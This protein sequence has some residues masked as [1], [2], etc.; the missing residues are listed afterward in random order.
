MSDPGLIERLYTRALLAIGRGRITAVSDG[1]AV[2]TMQVRLGADE[3][4]DDTP[5]LVE[6]GLSSVPPIGSDVVLLFVGGDR[7]MGVVVASGNQG[8]RPKGLAGGEVCLYDDL[9]Q[10]VH[11]TRHGVVVKGAG[12]PIT[13]EGT[14]SLTIKA[15]AK[16]RLETPLLEVTGD[17]VDQVGGGGRSMA[18]MRAIYNEHTHNGVQPGGASTAIPNQRE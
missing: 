2:Q 15:S 6:Y 10:S 13:I 7:S 12:L 18:S 14:P 16:V 1:G 11:L 17:V 9:G 3:L 8:A 5:R 4:R